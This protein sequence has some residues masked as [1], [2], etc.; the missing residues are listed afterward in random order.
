MRAYLYHNKKDSRPIIGRYLIC[1]SA[2]GFG[3]R[4]NLHVRD[5]TTQIPNTVSLSGNNKYDACDQVDYERGSENEP[6]LEKPCHKRARGFGNFIGYR[7]EDERE[8]RGK[9]VAAMFANMF[10]S[11]IERTLSRLELLF[12]PF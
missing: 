7:M 1:R 9:V 12:A 6:Q 10:S 4:S 2:C 11:I 5:G 8:E 3:S